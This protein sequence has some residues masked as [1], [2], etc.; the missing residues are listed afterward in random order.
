[1]AAARHVSVRVTTEAAL[2]ALLGIAFPTLFD[3]PDINAA[4]LARRRLVHLAGVPHFVLDAVRSVDG[5]L[6]RL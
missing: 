5:T 3:L 2:P 6:L 1:V 4:Y